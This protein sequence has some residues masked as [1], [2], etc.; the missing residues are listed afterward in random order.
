M[1][2]ALDLLRAVGLSGAGI[3]RVIDRSGA[4]KGS[5]YHYFPG[6]K[7]ELMAAALRRAELSV[8]DGLRRVFGRS[9]R[10]DEKVRALFTAAGIAMEANKFDRGCP[11]AAVTL[12]LDDASEDLRE[13][14]RAIFDVWLEIIAEGLEEVPVGDRREVA[15]LIL[16]T[17]EGS[18]IL[19][20][21]R[22][23]KDVLLSAGARLADA[24]AVTF[25]PRRRPVKRRKQSSHG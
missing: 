23:T 5:L 19:A 7:N 18:M 15:G 2:A 6:G 3:N 14:C 24:L 9:A 16:A 13:V 1:L 10:L 17:L 8:G 21:A 22:A 12:D 4:P 20:R 25:S 11:V